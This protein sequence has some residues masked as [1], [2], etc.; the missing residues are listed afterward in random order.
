MSRVVRAGLLVVPMNDSRGC[1]DDFG[2]SGCLFDWCG[3]LFGFVFARPDVLLLADVSLWLKLR[4]ARCAVRGLS[5]SWSRGVS[6]ASPLTIAVTRS[7]RT[8]SA[9]VWVGVYLRTDLRLGRF[10]RSGGRATAVSGIQYT[11]ILRMGTHVLAIAAI[12]PQQSNR[13]SLPRLRA[14]P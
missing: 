10:P 3:L 8:Q 7:V 5:I 1:L 9:R 14:W 2:R 4:C 6:L 13:R 12:R 11:P